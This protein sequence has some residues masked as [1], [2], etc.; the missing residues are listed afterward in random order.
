M[1]RIVAG[2]YKGLKIEQPDSKF[3]R[4]TTDKVREA[5][6]SSLQFKLENTT[7]L[8]LFAGSGAWSIESISR[9]AIKV[10]SV[11]KNKVVYKIIQQNIAKLPDKNS[12]NLINN[13]ALM[14]LDKTKNTYDFVFIDAPFIQY[15]LVSKCLAKLVQNNL[16]KEDFEIILE[17]DNFSNIILPKELKVYKNKKYGKIEILYLCQN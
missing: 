11:E 9:G 10:D 6:F 15:D 4:P 2:K 14:F 1:L 13:D 16:L 3:T 8:D 5:V 12:I 7:C 17:T